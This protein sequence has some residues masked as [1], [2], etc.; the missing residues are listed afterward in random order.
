MKRLSV[1]QD[2][3]QRLHIRHSQYVI[4]IDK[5]KAIAAF[6]GAGFFAYFMLLTIRAGIGEEGGRM[7]LI[8]SL[9]YLPFIIWLL[10]TGLGK[11]QN[12][13]SKS[14]TVHTF[15]PDH[16]TYHRNG[17]LVLHFNLLQNVTVRAESR[18]GGESKYTVYV[19]QLH[20]S[21]RK[22]ITI[23]SS[24]DRFEMLCAGD[25][26]ARVARCQLHFE[27]LSKKVPLP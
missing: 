19:L 5:S 1:H 15:D 14:A 4:R 2:A 13:R 10:I 23:D 18:D 20:T 21:L 17:H 12:A 9:I 7:T 3:D 8:I 6:L 11:R 24:S 16:Q 25:L 26:I 22:P 27:P